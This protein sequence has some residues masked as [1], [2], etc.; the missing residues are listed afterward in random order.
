MTRALAENGIGVHVVT[1]ATEVEEEFRIY[2]IARC[3]PEP[4]LFTSLPPVPNNLTVHTTEFD[5]GQSYVP[6][7]NPFVTKLAS[8]AADIVS[9]YDC[10]LIHAF[11]LEPYGVAAHMVSKWTNIPYGLQHAGTDI[12]RLYPNQQLTHSYRH[13]IREADYLIL[14]PQMRNLANQSSID[15][16]RIY[17]LPAAPPPR[18]Y[19]NPQARPLNIQNSLSIIRESFPQ[20]SLLADIFA[21]F[22][23]KDFNP[24]HP[25]IGIYGKLGERKGWRELIP[26]LG[27]LKQSGIDFNF[28]V[29]GQGQRDNLRDFR[30][31]VSAHGLV[32]RTYLLPFIPH[33]HVPHYIKACDIICVLE[34]RFPIRFH[35]P[36][37]PQEVVA[38]GTCLL[39]SSEIAA[40]QLFKGKV[41]SGE[42]CFV[43]EPTD[44]T[45][46]VSTLSQA[47]QDPEKLR[48]IGFRGH[49]DFSMQDDFDSYG[50]RLSTQFIRI[51]KEVR[52][53]RDLA[54]L[55]DGTV[56]LGQI[57][58]NRQL[59]SRL[60]GHMIEELENEYK[61]VRAFHIFKHAQQAYRNTFRL[62]KGEA[63]GCFYD[64][65]EGVT[66]ANDTSAIHLVLQFGDY[67]LERI[68][69]FA[70]SSKYAVDLLNYEKHL[71]LTRH[72][73]YS[74]ERRRNNNIKV[75][76]DD[77]PAHSN[78]I[79]LVKV[80]YDVPEI[81]KSLEEIIDQ[82]YI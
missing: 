54:K 72:S 67:L 2:D 29:L 21:S 17:P 48:K 59:E 12:G 28:V 24:K 34:N 16:G 31:T 43:V 5:V 18:D 41:A 49:D 11:Y 81:L 38:C 22:A 52:E 27:L 78:L 13:I 80:E 25:T 20:A 33:W 61:N 55:R 15:I 60:M 9:K 40:K 3:A 39:M 71:F 23:V 30:S 44:L 77:R 74:P 50:V 70:P 14:S 69:T 68:P 8:K 79:E 1:N 53:R 10:D 58:N 37:I 51:L 46:L 73:G 42:N 45:S 35:T 57:M 6:W 65:Y 64:F 47:I 7:A 36:S 19:F 4:D 32:D 76:P 56:L 82:A 62:F 75:Q 26:A 63:R 66:A